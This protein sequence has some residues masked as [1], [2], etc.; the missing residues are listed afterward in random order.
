MVRTKRKRFAMELLISM[1]LASILI[2]ESI[3]FCILGIMDLMLAL[4]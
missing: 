4:D 1:A 3:C 2:R